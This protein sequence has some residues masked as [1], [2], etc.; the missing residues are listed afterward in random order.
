MIFVYANELPFE[1]LYKMT[2]T[3]EIF[4][5]AKESKA[6]TLISFALFK[7]DKITWNFLK[8]VLTLH[9]KCGMI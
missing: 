6:N 8:N 5:H 9:L 4:Y 1:N 2:V 7:A 3:F